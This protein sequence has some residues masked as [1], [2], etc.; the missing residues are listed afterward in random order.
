MANA[1]LLH[2]TSCTP[3][4]FWFPSI[5]SF[6]ESQ[7]YRVWAPSL[8]NP[9]NPDLRAQLP[10]ILKN[11]TF[12]RNTAIIAH[13]AGCPLALSILENLKAPVSKTILVAGYA[14]PKGPK[15]QHEQILQKSYNWQKI[16]KNAGSLYMLNSDDDPWGCDHN[17]GLHMWGNLGGGTLILLHGEGHMGSGTFK[18]PYKQFPLLEKLITL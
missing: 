16:A 6:L 7:G 15:K 1:I 11:G 14:R 2:G 13:S 17:E 9:D 5:S 4:S 12:N 10:F 8:P 18:Q 3:A